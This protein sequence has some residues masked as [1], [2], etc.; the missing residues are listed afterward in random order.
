MLRS[1]R[2]IESLAA[3]EL[4][5]MVPSELVA[6]YRPLITGTVAYFASSTMS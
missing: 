5:G 3:N 4:L 6:A 2:E 1:V